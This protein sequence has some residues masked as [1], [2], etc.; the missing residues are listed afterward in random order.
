MQTLDLLLGL[1][2]RML[3]EAAPALGARLRL[4]LTAQPEIESG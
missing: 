1:N 3:A 4:P 2:E